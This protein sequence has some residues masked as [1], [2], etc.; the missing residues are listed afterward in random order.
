MS[1]EQTFSTSDLRSTAQDQL[2][3]AA[4][5]HKWALGSKS[6][7]GR[8]AGGK[9]RPHRPSETTYNA[10]RRES[11]GAVAALQSGI[12]VARKHDML[13]GTAVSDESSGSASDRDDSPS[14]IADAGYT[15]SFDLPTGPSQGSQILNAA[16][17]K[18]VAKFE[19][20]E[21]TKLVKDEYE[22]L[23]DEGE[24]I[25]LTPAKKS[26]KAKVHP[27]IVPDADDDY[28]II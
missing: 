26:R 14:P 16:L 15:F 8:A 24:S 21:V 18:A 25:G 3:D 19:D 7:S 22:V 27:M 28:E 23:D 9:P 5:K 4:H 1:S 17:A 12:K 10:K 6:T 20:R 2:R 11:R 13:E